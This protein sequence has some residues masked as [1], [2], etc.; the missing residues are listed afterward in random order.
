MW[1]SMFFKDTACYIWLFIYCIGTSFIHSYR[2][3]RHKHTYI[4]HNSY[5]IFSMTIAESR[6]INYHINM[7]VW[8]ILN[9]CFC[10]FRNLKVQNIISLIKRCHYCVFW[11][12]TYT[13]ATTNTIFLF[14]LWLTSTVHFHFTSSW[15][16][17]H[18]KIFLKYHQNL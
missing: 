15:T 6:N 3:K 14:N 2:V 11:T 4:W 8:S 18:A 13:S 7:E 1:M 16:T 9:Y 17:T 10:I 12:D 5:I